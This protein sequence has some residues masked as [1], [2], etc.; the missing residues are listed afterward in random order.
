MMALIACAGRGYAQATVATNNILPADYLGVQ[1]GNA[2]DL[3]FK[4]D[5]VERAR[6]KTD[7]SFL[8]GSQG[9]STPI[10]F[11]TFGAGPR[12]FYVPG[13][14][15]GAFRAGYVDNTSWDDGNI[16]NTSAAFGYN[17]LAAGY[18]SFAINS[19]T[20]ASGDRSFAAGFATAATGMRAFAC[21]DATTA[22][23][24]ASISLN[25][26]TTAESYAEA[27]F[28]RYNI[29]S[30]AYNPSGWVNIDPLFVIGNGASSVAPANALT[31]LKNGMTGYGS[32]TSP[33]YRIEIPNN[34]DVTGWGLAN[35]WKTYSSIRY[36]EHV[37]TIPEALAKVQQLRGVE[38]DWKPG[39][40][41]RHDIGFIAE[42]LG[43]VLPE[44]VDYEENGVDAKSVNYTAVIPVTIEAIKEQQVI[45][46]SQKI[47]IA[48]LKE[49]MTELEERLARLESSPDVHLGATP[50]EK[51][52]ASA[53]L[54]QNV[55]N[56]ADEA[57]I[58][59]YFLPR[60]A[61]DARLI[62]A[63][64]GSGREVRSIPLEGR[65]AGTVTIP[66]RELPA[67]SYLYS[68]V[69]DGSTTQSMRMSVMR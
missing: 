69:V 66:A 64:T 13:T 25:Y 61:R 17:T 7:G 44:V 9:G 22:S 31:I 65:G 38:F 5:G 15:S 8:Y 40:G 4:T 24:E 39:N 10:A 51:R 1:A 48:G 43:R 45:I 67:G 2:N 20:T 30:A 28:G 60:S 41:G 59:S 21:G 37:K 68:I 55:P 46:G 36:K 19:N 3:V 42:E 11:A 53:A 49:R 33:T 29:T 52:Q 14:R 47:E 27:V 54:A 32:I 35:A 58:I 57:T 16:G 18:T 26:N 56:P 12:M 50:D 6:M 23:G 62:V 63:E 34:A